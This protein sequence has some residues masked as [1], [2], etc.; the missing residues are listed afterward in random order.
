[1]CR[2]LTAA[3][4]WSYNKALM[5][6]IL[7]LFDPVI[8]GTVFVVCGISEKISLGK[9]VHSMDYRGNQAYSS[10]WNLP[11]GL[12]QMQQSQGVLRIAAPPVY[13]SFNDDYAYAARAPVAPMTPTYMQDF[14]FPT[15]YPMIVPSNGY[16]TVSQSSR[17]TSPETQVAYQEKALADTPRTSGVE[18]LDN[19]W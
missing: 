19:L 10:D 12:P 3:S 5:E 1:M 18:R 2:A 6:A 17:I 8:I 7:L 13:C 15:G 9:Q 16:N 11:H 14:S 4:K